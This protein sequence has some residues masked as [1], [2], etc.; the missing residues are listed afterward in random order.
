MKEIS[1]IS[2][3]LILA[4]LSLFSSSFAQDKEALA[5]WFLGLKPEKVV[6]AVNCGSDES[7]TD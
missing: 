2:S 1:S 6:Y 5:G 7:L 3:A 4:F